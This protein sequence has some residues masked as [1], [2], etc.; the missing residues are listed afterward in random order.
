MERIQRFFE[1]QAYGV[2][3]KLGEKL[4]LSA[5]SIRLFFIYASFITFG[6]P[7]LV[8]LGLAYIIN[9]RKHLRRRQN[10]VWYN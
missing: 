10:P 7:L 1:S 3:T 5:S 4:N 6:S 9:F 2:C 8:Y